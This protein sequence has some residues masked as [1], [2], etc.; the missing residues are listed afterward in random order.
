MV[1]EALRQVSK[2]FWHCLVAAGSMWWSTHD[3]DDRPAFV[4]EPST[5]DSWV[6][7]IVT[8]ECQRGLASLER[9]LAI[10][11]PKP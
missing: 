6:E 3:P 8:R 9:Y 5:A 2:F 10:Y 4:E 11:E 7:A 1:A